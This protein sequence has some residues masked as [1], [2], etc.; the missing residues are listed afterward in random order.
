[1][2]EHIKCPWCSKLVMPV[3]GSTSKECGNVKESKCPECKAI[4]AAYLEEEGRVLEKVRS[5]QD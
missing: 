2:D 3:I 5:F 4:L 1:M